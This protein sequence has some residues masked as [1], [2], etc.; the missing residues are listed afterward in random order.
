M[1]LCLDYNRLVLI[2]LTR[3]IMLRYVTT[4][5]LQCIAEFLKPPRQ[6]QFFLCFS[7]I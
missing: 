5:T 1:S 7:N 3:D 6:A 2:N 4:V